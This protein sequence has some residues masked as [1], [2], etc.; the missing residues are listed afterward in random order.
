MEGDS[1]TS[2]VSSIRVDDVLTCWPPGPPD[3]EARNP[4]SDSGIASWS[5][6]RILASSLSLP[7]PWPVFGDYTTTMQHR[8]TDTGSWRRLAALALSAVLIA[9][10][11][12]PA[13]P[14]RSPADSAI[15]TELRD[16]LI[17]LGMAD[18][19]ARLGFDV[20]ADSGRLR[21]MLAVDSSLT[22]RLRRIVEERGWPGRSLVGEDA[23]SAAFLIVQHSTSHAF[24]REML[25]L[26]EEAAA[27]G[28]ADASDVALLTDGVRTHEGRP[29]LY[30]TQFR[31]VN[32]ALEP[33][34]IE[35]PDNLDRRRQ[36]A[37]LLPMAEYVK[38]LESTYDGTVRMPDDTIG[39]L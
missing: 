24:Q 36:Q 28:E 21:L 32:G 14:G 37:G 16:E 6:I 3:L 35:D 10:E 15:D 12:G 7:L 9:C 25:V 4:S 39:S 27:A 20:A 26:L 34:P 1:A 2:Q 31:I 38:I 13:P 22:A 18:Q 29:Q 23:A 17:R 19:T 5:V 11:P 30:G 8:N 33:Y